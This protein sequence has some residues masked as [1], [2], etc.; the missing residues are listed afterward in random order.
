MTSS[1]Q[2]LA[3]VFLCL[4]S[5]ALARS[6]EPGKKL[7]LVKDGHA[8]CTI[9]VS[10]AGKGVAQEAAADLQ[11]YIDKAGGVKVAIVA[12]DR[13][14]E[15][16]DGTARIFVGPC[17]AAARVVDLKKLQ[18][19]GFVIK[20]DG[21]D[22]YIVGRDTT[23]AGLPVRGT[24][25]GV[26]EFLERFLGVRWLMPG[27]CG[28]VV[29]KQATIAIA[30][31]D[32]RQEPLLWQR[33]M[34][35]SKAGGH[36]DR[37]ERIL[38][39]WN[40]PL[41]QWQSTFSKAHTGPWFSHQRLGGRV[42]LS[43]GHS[44]GGW[45][46]RYHEKYPDIFAMQPNGTR[47]NTNVRE[48]L[49]VSNPT[50][51]DLVAQDRIRQ[52]RADPDLTAASISPNDGGQ[53]K[54]C[55]CER[56]RAWDSPQVQEIYKKNPKIEQGPEIP[57]T[58]RYCRF[59]NEVAKR[60]KQ[61]MPG[62]FL[63]CYA[64]SVY[65][66]P[67][68]VVDHLE[69]NLIVGYVAFSSY[70]SDQLRRQNREE[71][72]QWSKLAKQLM[73]RPNLLWGALGLPINYV[74]KLADDLRF[75]AD[76]GM[77]ATDYD[78]LVGNWGTQGLNCYVLARL[79]WD[80]YRQVDPIVDDYCRAAYGPGAEAMNQY[81][82]RLEELTDHIAAVTRQEDAGFNRWSQGDKLAAYYTDSVLGELQHCVDRALAAIGA[83]D[84]A[85][86]QRVGLV[87]TGLEYTRQTRR[88]LTAAADVRAKK[89]SR[90]EF[91]KVQAE[92]L[93]YYRTLALSWAV[94][95]DHNYSSLRRG[96]SLRPVAKA[97][98]NE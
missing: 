8:T 46:D 20:T 89:S 55:C 49:C 64:Y 25:Y 6:A 38:K 14:G 57:L 27:P 15:A 91:E 1:R 26:C 70:L 72:I 77:R 21:G 32:I 79:L 52:L 78:G 84:S 94:S 92:V 4:A 95:I 60:V 36:R 87:A 34:R 3:L 30:A 39:D 24:F 66:T 16:K 65:R 62:R 75:L 28:E 44:Y 17:R 61:E 19:E 29:P 58:D 41:A 51:W 12:E 90:Q 59:Y 74:H 18:P 7:V 42:K 68:V 35:D 10:S 9:V 13:L 22:L 43:Y 53:N 23:D 85:A 98:E 5:S 73:L 54:F 47:I 88:L 76:H 82:R 48:R 86:Q 69:D 93:A 2:R 31:A 96:L 50:L 81:Y 71:W 11:A 40:V 45:W 63:G 56:C 67:P 33:K 37:V 83:S 97:P 80:P